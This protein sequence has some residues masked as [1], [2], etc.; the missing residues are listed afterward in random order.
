MTRA[1]AD[2]AGERKSVVLPSEHELAQHAVQG[3]ADLLRSMQNERANQGW[4]LTRPM[5]L[6][7]VVL[8]T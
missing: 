4:A 2:E 1:H 3:L 6:L 5:F 8:C 7:C